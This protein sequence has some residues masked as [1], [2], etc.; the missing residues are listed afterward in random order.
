MSAGCDPQALIGI[1]DS[2]WGLGD[3]AGAI[4]R[5]ERALNA[6][7]GA[8]TDPEVWCAMPGLRAR[9]RCRQGRAWGLVAHAD[10]RASGAQFSAPASWALHGSGGDAVIRSVATCS[11]LVNP[12]LPDSLVHRLAASCR[13]GSLHW[14][15]GFYVKP[16][17]GWE[18]LWSMSKRPCTLGR[19]ENGR[20]SST[21]CARPPSL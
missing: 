1:G 10:A 15:R 2:L 13:L 6:S 14:E 17:R 3:E 5:Y 4:A 12:L 11:A 19:D 18:S 9:P 16:R 21:T 7:R 20:T 8:A